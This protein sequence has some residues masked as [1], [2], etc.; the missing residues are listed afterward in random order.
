MKRLSGHNSVSGVAVSR[1]QCH[2]WHPETVS[3]EDGIGGTKH[4]IIV[5][6]AV[7]VVSTA[8]GCGFSAQLLFLPAFSASGSSTFLRC[9]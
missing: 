9:L 3:G 8:C 4:R 6:V 5:V 2:T 7:V 1:G